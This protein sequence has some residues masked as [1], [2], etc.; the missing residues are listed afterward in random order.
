VLFLGDMPRFF[1][2]IIDCGD[3]VPDA[4]GTELPDRQAARKT[5]LQTLAEIARWEVPEKPFC[6]FRVRV[7][8]E[9]QNTVLNLW[10]EVQEGE[11]RDQEQEV[12]Y[13]DPLAER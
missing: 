7:R 12:I 1:F 8:D 4:E 9:Q 6:D 3:P 10:L 2:D 5:A 13:D 11:R